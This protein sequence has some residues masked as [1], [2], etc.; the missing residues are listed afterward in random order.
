MGPWI[1]T[2]TPMVGNPAFNHD[3]SVVEEEHTSGNDIPPEF[4]TTTYTLSQ[5]EAMDHIEIGQV[6]TREIPTV[7]QWGLIIMTLLLLTAGTIVLGR[8]RKLATA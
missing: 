8:R 7:S 1:Y 3:C 4:D 2:M 5:I 6:S